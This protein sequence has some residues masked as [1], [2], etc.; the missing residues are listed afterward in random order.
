MQ[1]LPQ[2]PVLSCAGRTYPPFE[3]KTTPQNLPQPPVLSCAGRTYPV[4][5]LFLEDV[6]EATRYALDPGSRWVLVLGIWQFLV[7][8][9]IFLAG[10]RRPP[11]AHSTRDPGEGFLTVPL[12]FIGI[13]RPLLGPAC[14]AT[15][16]ALDPGS[17][18]G[19]EGCCGL[20]FLSASGGTRFRGGASPLLLHLCVGGF[21]WVCAVKSGASPA[22][23]PK[24]NHRVQPK[25]ANNRPAP[26]PRAALRPGG[27]GASARAAKTAAK[28]DARRAGLL[29]AGWGDDEADCGALNPDWDDE[30]YA[31]YSALTRRC[32]RARTGGGC[33]RMEGG[34]WGACAAQ[35]EECYEC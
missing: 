17:R 23:T 33:A 27:R 18:R 9:G 31:D 10:C 14:R 5:R 21:A 20:S 22:N 19:F 34:I 7:L 4:E 28:G 29:R 15:R 26:P 2:P 16:C 3:L 6:Y 12:A 32:V 30:A 11:V 8:F 13:V 24:V 1:N 25:T 35:F